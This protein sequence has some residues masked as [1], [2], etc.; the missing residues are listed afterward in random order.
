MIQIQPGY[1][2]RLIHVINDM[3]EEAKNLRED[4]MTSIAGWACNERCA[5]ELDKWADT[6]SK[7]L[8]I[9]KEQ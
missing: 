7:A 6:I 1:A 9:I 3:R 5:N 4:T 2:N 8:F